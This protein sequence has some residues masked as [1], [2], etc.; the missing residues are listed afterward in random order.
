M[1][2]PCAVL[3][4]V[5]KFSFTLF[6]WHAIESKTSYHMHNIFSTFTILN[7]ERTVNALKSFIKCEEKKSSGNLCSIIKSNVTSFETELSKCRLAHDNLFSFIVIWT[8][9]THTYT[10]IHAHT[11]VQEGNFIFKCSECYNYW[12]NEKLANLTTQV[13]CIFFKCII[14]DRTW[15]TTH[16]LRTLKQH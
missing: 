9:N 16:H 10:N 4:F 1:V 7:T 11:S 3:V 5:I 12:L 6:R 15:S 13:W 14:N 2:I 8:E